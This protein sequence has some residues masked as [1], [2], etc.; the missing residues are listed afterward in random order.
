MHLLSKWGFS[1]DSWQGRR[2]EYW[3]FAQLLLI[4]GFISLP[5]YYPFH[6]STVPPLLWWVSGFGFGITA[7]VFLIIRN[8]PDC[9]DYRRRVKKLVPELY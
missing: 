3:V 7:F 2:G 6:Q 4:L 9:A 5:V 1:V 8:N